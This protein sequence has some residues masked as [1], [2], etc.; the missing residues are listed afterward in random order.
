MLEVFF[1]ERLKLASEGYITDDP[2]EQKV[3]GVG[4]MDVVGG[5]LNLHAGGAGSD[6]PWSPAGSQA[7]R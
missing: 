4:V 1:T 6:A 2:F 5:V 7:A 3:G